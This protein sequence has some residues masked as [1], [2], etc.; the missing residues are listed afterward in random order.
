MFSR[1]RDGDDHCRK[2]YIVRIAAV[3]TE[4]ED[5]W[6][7]EAQAAFI[8]FFACLMAGFMR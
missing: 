8:A 2:S 6:D 1:N 7:E 3:F 4:S 5:F